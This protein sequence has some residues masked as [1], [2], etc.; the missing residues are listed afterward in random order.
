MPANYMWAVAAYGERSR[1]L[2]IKP[3]GDLALVM[4]MIRV[5]ID[6]ERYQKRILP[7]QV[8]LHKKP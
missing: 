1:W 4:G 3:S 8:M 6:E 2:P 5:I 7:F